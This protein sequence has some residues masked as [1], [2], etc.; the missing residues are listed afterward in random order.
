MQKE[1]KKKKN[2]VVDQQK[3]IVDDV[4]V[5]WIP[6]LAPEGYHYS[7]RIEKLAFGTVVV[8]VVVDVDV[9]VQLFRNAQ[10]KCRLKNY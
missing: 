7:K 4:T 10:R 6:N 3:T 9:D 1:K 8:V 5:D 2:V